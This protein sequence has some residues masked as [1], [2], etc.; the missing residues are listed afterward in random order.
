[1]SHHILAK[2]AFLAP[3]LVGTAL[4]ILAIG[5]PEPATPRLGEGTDLGAIVVQALRAAGEIEEDRD[6][7]FFLID[8]ARFHS[9]AGD[10]VVAQEAAQQALQSGRAI[11]NPIR[12]AEVL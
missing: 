5:V 12:R 1:M 11:R 6:R 4:P 10:R 8:L 9:R 7:S 2:F 3:T